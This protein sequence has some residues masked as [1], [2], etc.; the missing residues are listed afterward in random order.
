MVLAALLARVLY[1]QQVSALLS[2]RIRWGIRRA[3]SRARAR[4]WAGH[5]LPDTPFF[6]GGILYPWALA[7]FALLFG[8]NLYPVCL[9]QALLGCLLVW[10][11]H[12]LCVAAAGHGR[13][14]LGRRAGLAAAAM[15]ALYGPFAFLEA[16]ILMVSWTL[17]ALV[18]SAVVLLRARRRAAR[19]AEAS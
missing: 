2:S 12:R 18:L 14:R 16:D 6:Y 19:G 4:S 5:L 9:A 15:A 8:A 3:P 17:P 1:L 11:I 10:S 7:G 13:R